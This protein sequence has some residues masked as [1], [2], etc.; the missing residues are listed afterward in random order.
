MSSPILQTTT[1]PLQSLEDINLYIEAQLAETDWNFCT[2]LT[3]KSNVII[4]LCQNESVVV[5]AIRICLSEKVDII[6]AL[7]ALNKGNPMLLCCE[8]EDGIGQ[9]DYAEDIVKA[10]ERSSTQ[11]KTLA[12]AYQYFEHKPKGRGHAISVKVAR[13]V[14][15]ESH[16]YCMFEGC[17]EHL[18]VD[19][20]T[21]NKGNFRYLAHIVASSPDGP[22]G[23][24]RSHELSN[25][26]ENIMVLCDK[27]H[28][29]I[30]KVAVGEYDESRLR[31]MRAEFITNTDDLLQSL[32]YQPVTTFTALWPIGNFVTE[33]PSPH[34]YAVS[35]K[36]VHCR[37]SGR[38]LSLINRS[39]EAPVDDQWWETIVP[40]E[41]NHVGNKFSGY[42]EADR[43]HAGLYAMGPSSILIGL[44]AVLGNKNNLCV[45]PR[46]RQ[47]GW[48]WERSTPI[49]QPFI[50][51]GLE[52]LEG[53]VDELAITLFF[54]AVPAE[55]LPVLDYLKAQGVDCIHI[56]PKMPGNTCLAHPHEGGALRELFLELLHHLRNDFKVKRVHLLHC[57]PNAACVE[58]GRGIEHNHPSIRIY[59]HCKSGDD[60][61]MVPRLDLDPSED[62]VEV[63][64]A[65]NN[66]VDLFHQH[67]QPAAAK[68]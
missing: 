48:R 3:D 6:R 44:G 57:A 23:N 54:T 35:L 62:R 45:V 27:H 59:D 17:G 15:F 30:D 28:R 64:G 65:P 38:P 1:A 9:I 21:G 39:S 18:S 2:L 55:S 31:R 43:R 5:Q 40:R 37:P 66:D 68:E 49:S 24:Q 34:E 16:G 58:V 41:I 32:A 20:L 46:S 61:Y 12:H 4:A 42:S 7:G 63:R 47:N 33:G 13:E 51:S 22:R 36:P 19:H 56:Q 10:I 14:V 8:V 60:K 11:K 50:I 52:D 67:F 25:D 29:L 53:P 26:P